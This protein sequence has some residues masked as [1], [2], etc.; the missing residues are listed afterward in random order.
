MTT[1]A[2]AAGRTRHEV[3]PVGELPP[4]HMR[5]FTTGRRRILVAAFPGGEYRAMSD[6]CPHHGASLSQGQLER[7]WQAGPDGRHMPDPDRW[8]V[9]CP[10]HNYEIDARTGCPVVKL[11]RSRAATYDVAVEAGTVVLYI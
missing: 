9:V 11:G 10:F 1:A 8:V 4:G 6:Y 7:M 2:R 3:C 5:L